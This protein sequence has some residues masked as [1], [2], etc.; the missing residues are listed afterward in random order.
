MT[1]DK[2]PLKGNASPCDCDELLIEYIDSFGSNL[3]NLRQDIRGIVR[4][5]LEQI[6]GEELQ[7]LLSELRR[8][9]PYIERGYRS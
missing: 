5:E 7:R 8:P 4:E 3:A 9:K 6:V 1:L 2:L